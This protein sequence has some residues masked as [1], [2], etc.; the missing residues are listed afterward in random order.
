MSNHVKK[1]SNRTQEEFNKNLYRLKPCIAK[2]IVRII[3]SGK[4]WNTKNDFQ[5]FGNANKC[6]RFYLN[7][8][9]F[10]SFFRSFL[11][12]MI[13]ICTCSFLSSYKMTRSFCTVTNLSPLVFSRTSSDVKSNQ[14]WTCKKNVKWTNKSKS[15][16]REDRSFN[17][18][19]FFMRNSTSRCFC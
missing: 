14:T 10:L 12:V 8:L 3:Q 4:H 16:S 9:D 17:R 1:M 11:Y 5:I 6:V 18:K 15:L 13:E 7:Y 2:N 19:H